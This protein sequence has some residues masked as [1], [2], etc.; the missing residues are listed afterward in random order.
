M[1]DGA[2]A[3]LLDTNT[4]ILLSRLDDRFVADLVPCQSGNPVSAIW[5]QHDHRASS[6]RVYRRFRRHL[7]QC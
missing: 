3:G 2:V 6:G 5:T 7:G 1:S 4:V